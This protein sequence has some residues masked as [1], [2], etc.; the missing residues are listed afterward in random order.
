MRQLDK[1]FKFVIV[2]GGSAG[3]MAAIYLKNY[4]PE[5]DITV[6]ASSEYGI[7][8]AGEA[9]APDIFDFLSETQIP[10]H[11]FITATKATI[12]NEGLFT[13]WNGDGGSYR[14]PVGQNAYGYQFAGDMHTGRSMFELD[15]IAQGKNL[16]ELHLATLLTKRGKVPFV[17]SDQTPITE[18]GMHMDANLGAKFL[19]ETALKRNIKLIDSK[20]VDFDTDEENVLT[21]VILEDGTKIPCD[22]V[23]DCSG[24][25]KLIIGNYYK[26]EWVSYQKYL[27]VNRAIPFFEQHSGTNIRCYTEA[28]AMKYGW[29]WKTP[30]QDRYGYGY[31]FD[32]RFISEDQAKQEIDEYMGYEVVSPQTFRFD[33]GSFKTPWVNNCIALGLSAGFIEPLEGTAIFSTLVSLRNFVERITYITLGDKKVI[34]KYNGIIGTL[35]KSFLEFLQFHYI[36]KRKDTEFWRDFKTNNELLP[37]VQEMVDTAEYT[38]PNRGIFGKVHGLIPTHYWYIVG[39]GLEVWNP[40]A[41]KKLF[42]SYYQGKR[43]ILYEAQKKEQLFKIQKNTVPMMTHDKFLEELANLS[44]LGYKRSGLG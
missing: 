16:D 29:M 10:A 12:K 13:N 38:V 22:F 43:G 14:S 17:A 26:S 20:V 36:T 33:P 19:K 8:G 11:H 21:Q 42:D 30:V 18:I 32:S 39:A 40:E 4:F 25:R 2:G 9:V 37:I 34:E 5:T 3:W 28:I 1:N 41:A 15:Y 31:V 6:I 44:K 7:L 27:P 24:F 35:N 23:F